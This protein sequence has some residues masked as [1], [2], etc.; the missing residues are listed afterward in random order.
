MVFL[1][2][3]DFSL[4]APHIVLDM[5]VSVLPPPQA[6]LVPGVL[7]ASLGSI[8]GLLRYCGMFHSMYLACPEVWVLGKLWV[9]RQ[10]QRATPALLAG[11]TWRQ[12]SRNGWVLRRAPAQLRAWRAP[13]PGLALQPPKLGFGLCSERVTTQKSEDL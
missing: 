9:G 4:S 8:K 12:A 10:R 11:S 7:R 13:C 5:P 6:P 3:Y 1:T 2:P